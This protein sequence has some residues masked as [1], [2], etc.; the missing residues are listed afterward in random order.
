[1]PADTLVTMSQ[2]LI[3]GS[4]R[5]IRGSIVFQT[6]DGTQNE[7]SKLA[8]GHS[9]PEAAVMCDVTSTSRPTGL[10]HG[11]ATDEHRFAFQSFT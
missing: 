5:L 4:C 2:P 8:G 11:T 9:V 6:E 3:P 7:A 10:R 1:M